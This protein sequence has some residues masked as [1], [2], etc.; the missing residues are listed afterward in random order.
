MIY[1]DNAATTFPKPECVYSVMDKI[2]R[3]SAVNTGRGSYK[4]AREMTELIDDTRKKLL[5][6][7]SAEEF[8]SVIFTP[9][10][11]QAFNQIINGLDY[12]CSQTI[13][14]SLYEH[15]AV[16]RTVNRMRQIHMV[17]AYS[18]PNLESGEI[19]LEQAEYLFSK[20]VPSVIIIS[21]VSNTTGYILPY[22]ELFSLA[23][24]AN[25]GCITI[26]DAAQA[27]GLC[28]I[29][30]C[31]AD[32]DIICFAGH[33]TLYGP[34]GVGGFILKTGI[35][36]NGSITGGTGSDSL[37]KNMPNTIPGKYEAGSQNI[38]AIAGLNAA[39]SEVD[40][41]EHY[42]IVDELTKYLVNEL[43]TIPKVRILGYSGNN[44]AIVSFIVEGYESSDV[45]II[46]DE[47]FSIAVRTGFHCAP[48]IHKEF[49]DIRYGG[50]IRVGLGMFN[51]KS[52]IDALIG[53]LRTL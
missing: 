52:D 28:D 6:L 49:D 1:L 33:K 48:D 46:L 9:S 4:I 5:K 37:N 40:V 23:K 13:V 43:C 34:F 44:I 19:D 30:M 47:E 16:A 26:L 12:S 41:K 15:N 50:T 45:G 36:I 20:D 35:K 7:F 3:T 38:V 10:I 39:L 14:T 8:A 21:A 29:N 32:A 25:P 17:N 31:E 18:I 42:A 51:T 27:A 11:T 2:N 24:K 22:K 53:A